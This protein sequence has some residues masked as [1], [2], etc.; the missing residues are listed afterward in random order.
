MNI[1]ENITFLEEIENEFK[2]TSPIDPL[3]LNL[4]GSFL[5]VMLILGVSF[6]G[7]LLI[8]FKNNNDLK[9]PLNMLIIAITVLNLIGCITE[10]PWVVFSSFSHRYLFECLFYIL[11]NKLI[12][13][14]QMDIGKTRL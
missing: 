1:K 4:L 3:V 14:K 9:T 13:K 8:I 12:I 10:L 5:T 7:V 6:N 2:I 11:N